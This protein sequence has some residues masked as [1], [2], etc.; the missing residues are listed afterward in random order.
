MN[1]NLMLVSF[2]I[3]A[4]LW[5]LVCF[6]LD[7]LYGKNQGIKKLKAILRYLGWCFAQGIDQGLKR[8]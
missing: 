6:T 1:Y 7:R 8:K 3:S 4:C 5:F 2:L